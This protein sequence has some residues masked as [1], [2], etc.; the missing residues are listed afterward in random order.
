MLVSLRLTLK[1]EIYTSNVSVLETLLSWLPLTHFCSSPA[2]I[3]AGVP[4]TFRRGYRFWETTW[5]WVERRGFL[6][7]KLG[8]EFELRK[9]KI[10]RKIERERKRE[11]EPKSLRFL[12]STTSH[13]SF[14]FQAFYYTQMGFYFSIIFFFTH[15][16]IA[17]P[18]S[19]C[20]S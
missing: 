4:S 8:E 19:Y 5:I 2:S 14:T 12:L 17:F 13:Q 11:E 1:A 18:L 16:H 10:E 7:R 15:L 9:Y 6:Q 20:Y 3:K